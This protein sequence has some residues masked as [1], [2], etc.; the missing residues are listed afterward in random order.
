MFTSY[1]SVNPPTTYAI[2]TIICLQ[3]EKEEAEA[4]RD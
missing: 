4:Q 1:I 2:R 3:F